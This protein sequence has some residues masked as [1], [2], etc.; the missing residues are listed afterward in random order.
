MLLQNLP[1]DISLPT[2]PPVHLQATALTLGAVHG[3]T[4]ELAEAEAVVQVGGWSSLL[5]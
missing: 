2:L 5:L 3:R 1:C 4:V